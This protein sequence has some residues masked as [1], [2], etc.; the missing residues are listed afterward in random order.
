[1]DE[2]RCGFVQRLGAVAATGLITPLSACT[3]SSTSQGLPELRAART[4]TRRASATPIRHVIIACEENHSFDHYFGYA[5]F[6]E[7]YGV[8]AGYSQPSTFGPNPRAE[9]PHHLKAFTTADPSHEWGPMHRIRHDGK[10]D[11]FYAVNGS[12]ALGYY[13]GADLPFY[14]QLFNGATLCANYFCSVLGPTYPNR[15]YLLSGTSGGNTSNS[16]AEGA[17]T[18]PCILDLLDADGVTFKCYNVG[19][20]CCSTG[21][22]AFVFFKRYRS[23]PRVIAYTQNHYLHDLQHG[24]LPSVSFIMSADNNAEHPGYDIRTGMHFQQRFITA[25]QQSAYWS[26]AAYFLTWDECG[27]FFDHATPPVFDAYGAGVRVPTFVVSP[28]A[29][30]ANLETTLY[31]H[32][33]I[34]KFVEYVFGLP[35]LASVNHRFD[36]STPA[37]NNQAAKHGKGPP[38]PPRDALSA[39][40]DM[41]ECFDGL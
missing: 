25:L 3:D 2:T 1:M 39:T 9:R 35:S 32:A 31:D 34:L 29:K 16:I 30:P 15:L 22:N 19:Q 11:G 5:P 20:V 36:T 40:G 12:I 21:N 7:G 8:P 27:G 26:S 18:Y 14:Y 13:D 37:T 33:S 6:T 23:D 28:F 24:T 4:A 17:L 10:M 38:A 41:R